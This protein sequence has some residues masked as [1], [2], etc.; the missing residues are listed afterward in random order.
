[1]ACIREFLAAILEHIAAGDTVHVGRC[2][3][4]VLDTVLGVVVGPDGIVEGVVGDPSVAS[5]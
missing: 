4:V 2:Q 3:H 1:M 5:C